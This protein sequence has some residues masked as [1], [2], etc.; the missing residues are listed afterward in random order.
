M[1]RVWVVRL[2]S[3]VFQG[4]LCFPKLGGWESSMDTVCDSLCPL[5]NCQVL[6]QLSR[7]TRLLGVSLANQQHP[8]DSVLSSPEGLL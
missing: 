2:M 1:L 5:T 6:S 8:I 3:R 7:R 4:A